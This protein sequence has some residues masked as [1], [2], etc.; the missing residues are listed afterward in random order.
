MRIATSDAD[1][2]IIHQFYV[3]QVKFLFLCLEKGSFPFRFEGLLQLN[4]H[5]IIINFTPF[6]HFLFLFPGTE[7]PS[8][9]AVTCVY[10]WQQR[11]VLC[12]KDI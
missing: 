6:G 7:K 4:H 12:P 8:L 1:V 3:I 11:L 2:L 9:K 10:D 5:S